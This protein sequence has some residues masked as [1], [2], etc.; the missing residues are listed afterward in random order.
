MPE[1]CEIKQI[2]ILTLRN[3]RESI[4]LPDRRGSVR[5]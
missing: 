2:L 3:F 5:S 4:L 1:E